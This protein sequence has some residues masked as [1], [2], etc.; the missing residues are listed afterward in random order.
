MVDS[1]MVMAEVDLKDIKCEGCNIFM[2]LKETLRLAE[3][4]PIDKQGKPRE[5]RINNIWKS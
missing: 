3:F 1:S 4:D 2:D 5:A